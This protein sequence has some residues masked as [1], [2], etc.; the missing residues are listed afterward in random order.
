MKLPIGDKMIIQAPVALEDRTYI[1]H[2]RREIDV[3]HLL[4]QHGMLKPEAK[5]D[6]KFV[7]WSDGVLKREHNP[8]KVD[9]RDRIMYNIY[10]W[11]GR[12]YRKKML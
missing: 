8:L 2:R 1:E 6:A 7:G 9:A 12:H 10:Y 5:Q 3:S 11:E 4:D